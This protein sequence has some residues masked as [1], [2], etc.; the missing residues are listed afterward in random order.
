MLNGENVKHVLR[1]LERETNYR[2]YHR[3]SYQFIRRSTSVTSKMAGKRYRNLLGKD[4]EGYGKILN[5][6]LIVSVLGKDT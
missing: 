1:T 4:T 6:S 3:A 5:K 2:A